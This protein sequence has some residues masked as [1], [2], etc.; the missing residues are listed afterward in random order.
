LIA[1]DANRCPIRAGHDMRA[2]AERFDDADD[3]VDLALPSMCCHYDEHGV[4]R[5]LL[6]RNYALR[7]N[8]TR[9]FRS[10]SKQDRRQHALD[11]G[12]ML[13]VLRR[14]LQS[15]TEILGRFVNR[16]SGPVGGNFKQNPSRFAEIDGVKVKTIDHW[17]HVQAK[18]DNSRAPFQLLLVAR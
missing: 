12:P 14:Q 15:V 9:V 8:L 11:L 13:L 18:S 7:S 17:R 6:I 1:G 16:K 4:K 2:K 5:R 3:V 10:W